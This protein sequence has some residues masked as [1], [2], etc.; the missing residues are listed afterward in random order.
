M[1]KKD[2]QKEKE[3]ALLKSK[4]SYNIKKYRKDVGYTQEEL[5]ELADISHDF[6]RR[7]ES[8]DGKNSLS[9]FTLY[10]IA[11]ALNVSIDELVELKLKD[12][13][14]KCINNDCIKILS[15]W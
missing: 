7:I 5:S 6:M 11:L 2:P 4:I 14:K 15:M 10:K 1:N 9:I 8:S 3:K 13:W 12:K